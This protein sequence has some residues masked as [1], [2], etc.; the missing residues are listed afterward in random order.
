MDKGCACIHT[1]NR[2]NRLGNIRFVHVPGP[3]VSYRVGSHCHRG[4]CLSMRKALKCDL[5]RFAVDEVRALCRL[6]SA[7]SLS[8]RKQDAVASAH[9]TTIMNLHVV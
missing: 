7:C 2:M 6:Y 4:S 5:A 9:V 3:C 8:G 1:H